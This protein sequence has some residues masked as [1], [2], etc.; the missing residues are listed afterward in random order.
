[1]WNGRPL[2]REGEVFTRLI[3]PPHHRSDP[4]FGDPPSRPPRGSAL[5]AAAVLLV[6]VEPLVLLVFEEHLSRTAVMPMHDDAARFLSYAVRDIDAA[7]ATKEARDESMPGVLE[8]KSLLTM[9][10]LW[11]REAWAAHRSEDRWRRFVRHWPQSSILRAIKKPMLDILLIT[12]VVIVVNRLLVALALVEKAP[13]TLPLAPISL[14]AA[15]IGLLLVF[16]NNQTH[17]RL[18]E[19]QKAM[20]GLHAL[21]RETLQLLVIHV[22]G[23]RARDVGLAARLLA[24]FG[25]AL[26][27]QM[28]ADCAAANSATSATTD[29][30]DECARALRPIAQQLLPSAYAWLLAQPD[31]PAAVLLRL[32][33]VVGKLRID[34]HLSSDAF[35]FIEERLAKV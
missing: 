27:A 11:N 32:R 18:A 16:R 29:A 1:M 4:R 7:L 26:K 13:L 3:G 34:G 14:Q 25:W 35:K 2:R 5:P 24:L 19:A 21:G 23:A 8:R 17:S 20:G 12:T 30:S 10:H 28:R 9:T 15:S 33:A 22:P 6:F 31:R